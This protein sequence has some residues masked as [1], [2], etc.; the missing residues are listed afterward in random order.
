MPRFASIIFTLHLVGYGYLATNSGWQL[1]CFLRRNF[2]TTIRRDLI[3]WS[4][5]HW[6]P[7]LVQLREPFSESTTRTTQQRQTIRSPDV[8]AV[9]EN[10]S[11]LTKRSASIPFR[12]SFLQPIELWLSFGSLWSSDF[13]GSSWAKA[14]SATAVFSFGWWV[15]MILVIQHAIR[16]LGL[17]YGLYG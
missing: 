10:Q 11:G 5:Q 8:T 7:S 17:L 13:Q 3:C 1:T 4:R 2:S 14:E 12:M 16:L 15:L 9:K 6:L